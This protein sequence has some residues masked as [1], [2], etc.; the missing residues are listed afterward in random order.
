MNILIIEDERPAVDRLIYMIKKIDGSANVSGI[1]VSVKES[2]AWLKT[3]PKPDLIFLDV[4]LS[5]GISMEIFNKVAVSSPII[6]VTAYDEYVMEAFNHTTI[7]YLLKPIKEQRLKY[8]LSKYAN[9]EKHFMPDYSSLVRRLTNKEKEYRKRLT[10]KSG[11]EFYTVNVGDIAFFYTEYKI[12]FLQT[13]GSD[14]YILDRTLNELESELDPVKF[15]R[16]NRKIIVNLD[17]IKK[18]KTYSNGKLLVEFTP[19]F[20]ETVTVS[21]EKA[22]AFRKWMEG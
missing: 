21:R 11:Q 2:V 14:K 1:C 22:A 17:C 20:K 4:H 3:N 16:I 12:V 18:Y 6:F 7:D 5:D 10:V 15:F 13:K 8:A 9:L 19:R